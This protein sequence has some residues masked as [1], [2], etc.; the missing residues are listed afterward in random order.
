MVK[1][2]LLSSA[3]IGALATSAMAYNVDE[4]SSM[5]QARLNTT[6]VTRVVHNNASDITAIRFSQ[7]QTS[8]ALIFPAYFVG[9][10]WETHL[11]VVNTANQGVV[12]KVV[13][14][15]GKDSHEVV[16]FNI[17]LSPNDVWT[18]TLKVDNDGVAKI[19]STDDSAP[20]ENGDMASASNPLSKAVDSPTGY[21]EVIAMAETDTTLNT[22][23][24][25]HG[26]HKGLRT[27]YNMFAKL[28]R[29]GTATP[30]L[31]FQNGVVQNGVA[32]YPYLDIN[33]SK[34]SGQDIDSDG[35]IEYNLTALRTTSILTGDVRITYTGNGAEKDM[36]LP[37]YK[38]NYNIN[39]NLASVTTDNTSLI[40]LEGEK[41]NLADVEI[42]GSDYNWTNIQTDINAISTTQT[43]LAYGDA[44]PQ[45]MQAVVSNPFKRVYVQAALDAADGTVDGTI[46]TTN[47]VKI[48]DNNLNP[49]YYRNASI[50]Q[51]G[52]ISD[53]NYGST[54]LVAQI[55]DESENMMS[56][57]QFSPATTPTIELT[58]EV[59]STGTSLTDTNSLAYY[60]NQAINKG[61]KKGFVL[62][63]NARGNTVRI[64]GIVTQM[65]ATDVNGRIIT[66]WFEPQR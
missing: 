59:S 58:R 45:N 54:K 41:A 66:N 16:D 18:G 47:L 44:A 6:E 33:L 61:Y 24:T 4:L 7:I 29:T 35:N 34:L 21:V 28:M 1:K 31:I 63:T 2:F 8:N 26:D 42:N 17:Y 36:I 52:A 60:I 25:G 37:A 14:F 57:G 15:D 38:V 13:F 40:Y 3:V 11:R 23:K 39:S 51:G 5:S 46:N 56:A 65:I 30:N 12:A 55:F 43:Y 53:I 10:G 9:N 20:L 64:P 50:P 49:T 32:S 22:Y 19:I 62:L 27:A 48:T